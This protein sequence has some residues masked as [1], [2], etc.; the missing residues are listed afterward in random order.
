MEMSRREL[1]SETLREHQTA[2]GKP[3][4]RGPGTLKSLDSDRF[5]CGL[6]TVDGKS[7]GEI[8]N[9]VM[10]SNPCTGEM[11]GPKRLS[12]QKGGTMEMLENKGYFL[13]VHASVRFL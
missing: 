3:P 11:A 10:G 4:D 6:Q 8:S 13:P 7:E 9:F 1:L 2:P 12:E 5:A